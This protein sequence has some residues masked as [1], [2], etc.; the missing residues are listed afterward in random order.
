LAA[1]IWQRAGVLH[2]VREEPEMTAGAKL[3]TQRLVQR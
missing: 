1:D 2:L 3:P